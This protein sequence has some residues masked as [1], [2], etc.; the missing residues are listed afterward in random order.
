MNIFSYKYRR[1]LDRKLVDYT[2]DKLKN[3]PNIAYVIIIIHTIFILF[4]FTTLLFCNKH[5]LFYNISLCILILMIIINYY[6]DACPI[7]QVE[8]KLLNNKNWYGFPYNIIFNIL[9]IKITKNRVA[10]IFWSFIFIL[11]GYSLS[12]NYE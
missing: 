12:N 5:N 9:N 6:F 4:C 1:Q 8:R 11:L 10:A 3:I 7:T 2:Y